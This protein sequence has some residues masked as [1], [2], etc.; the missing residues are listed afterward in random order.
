M[1]KIVKHP[2]LR[3]FSELNSGTQWRINSP[4]G[5]AYKVELVINI[6]AGNIVTDLLALCMRIEYPEVRCCINPGTWTPLPSTIVG[7]EIPINQ[8]LHEIL[9]RE[10]SQQTN[11]KVALMNKSL[12]RSPTCQ[13]IMR[14]LVRY[15]AAIVLARL[16]TQ[17]ISL[18]DLIAASTM[19][20]PVLPSFHLL[21][22]SASSA[23]PWWPEPGT[24]WFSHT[25]FE[26]FSLKGRPM[27]T[28]GWHATMF[29]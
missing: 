17:P 4:V 6:H 26:Y 22:A 25:T 7:G 8:I 9:Y 15:I 1:N 12:T 2:L 16:C 3:P 21:T 29:V 18:M 10:S 23:C 11:Q 13:S 24:W 19:G 27:D 28:P 5:S 14:F 20:T